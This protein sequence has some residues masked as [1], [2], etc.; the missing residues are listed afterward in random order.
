MRAF[1]FVTAVVLFTACDPMPS[2]VTIKSEHTSP[3][4]KHVATA[5]IRD[6]GATTSWSPQVEL[7]RVGQRAAKY[8]NVFLG[9]G[10]PNVDTEWLS[11]SWLVVYCDTNCHVDVFVTNQDGI[12]VEMRHHR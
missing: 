7:R 5:F 3:D 1:I 2:Q 6:S 11:P 12:T 4:G 9:Y 8:G 10:S